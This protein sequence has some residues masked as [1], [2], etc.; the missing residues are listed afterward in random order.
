MRIAFFGRSLPLL[1][2][3][4][5]GMFLVLLT[6]VCVLILIETS[7]SSSD[8]EARSGLSLGLRRLA[9]PP[10]LSF[11]A[12]R[13]ISLSVWVPLFLSLIVGIL[14]GLMGVGGGF[15]TFPLLI[16][17]I[18]VPT[19]VAIGTSAFNLL[20]AGGY[21]AFRHALQHHVELLLVGILFAGAIAGIQ[22]GVFVSRKLSG[23]SIRRYFALVVAAG[24]VVILWDLV[25]GFWL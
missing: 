17:I 16:Y 20:F 25:K 2:I 5:T 1:D 11:P 6:T 8:Q 24:I 10:L 14:T 13:V 3:V 23:R 7:P 21:G 4:L 18:G 15:V 19:H 9:F 22:L 12:S